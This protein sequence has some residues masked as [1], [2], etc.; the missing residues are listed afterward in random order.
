MRRRV[1][2]LAGVLGTS[3]ACG[4]FTGGESG[5]V[6]RYADS[7][8]QEEADAVLLGGTFIPW[9]GSASRRPRDLVSERHAF[10]RIPSE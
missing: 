6:F 2:A 10:Y 1:L 5:S 3:V 9:L 8:C 7:L 4:N